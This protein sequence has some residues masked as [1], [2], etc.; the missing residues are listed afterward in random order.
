MCIV[1]PILGEG[2]TPRCLITTGFSSK[3]IDCDPFFQSSHTFT[4]GN[5]NPNHVSLKQ[6]LPNL[7]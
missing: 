5:S 1:F 7:E 3:S 6:G 4:L 2:L